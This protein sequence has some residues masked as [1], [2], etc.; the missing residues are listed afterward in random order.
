MTLALVSTSSVNAAFRD[1]PELITVT[2]EHEL[3]LG[4]LRFHLFR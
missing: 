4:G 3:A 2:P 1:G